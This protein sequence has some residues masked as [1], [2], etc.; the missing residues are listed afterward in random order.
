MNSTGFTTN[1]LKALLPKGI[2]TNANSSYQAYKMLDKFSNHYID[3]M[4]V[5]DTL[6]FLP[7]KPIQPENVPL[8]ILIQRVSYTLYLINQGAANFVHATL[9]YCFSVEIHHDKERVLPFM[10]MSGDKENPN[11]VSLKDGD[12]LFFLLKWMREQQQYGY[13]MTWL[14]SETGEVEIFDPIWNFEA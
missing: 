8:P 2:V 6:V 4:A 13:G 1:E 9:R 12:I 3:E 10:L 7:S 14:N 5:G 11:A